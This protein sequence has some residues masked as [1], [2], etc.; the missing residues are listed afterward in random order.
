MMSLSRTIALD[1]SLLRASYEGNEPL[2]NEAAKIYGDS[3]LSRLKQIKW[4]LENNKNREVAQAPSIKDHFPFFARDIKQL[5]GAYLPTY[6]L[7][8]SHT[9]ESDEPSTSFWKA[10]LETPLCGEKNSMMER[11]FS[12]NNY[13]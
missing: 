1:M 2:K 5:L 3:I 10:D 12:Q 13:L 4:L 8:L 9:L 7:P 11:I 6:N